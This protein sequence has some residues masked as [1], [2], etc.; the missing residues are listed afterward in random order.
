MHRGEATV[1]PR[2]L[3]GLIGTFVRPARPRG[4]VPPG[5]LSV[6][7]ERELRVLELIAHGLS[8]TQIAQEVGLSVSTVKNRVS[9]LFA[10]LGIR[11][12]AQAVIVAY[13]AGLVRPGD[14]RP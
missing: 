2:L 9:D 3:I 6:L 1:A 8:N 11:D 5:E 7:S 13:E 4:F 12:R 10:K 14:G